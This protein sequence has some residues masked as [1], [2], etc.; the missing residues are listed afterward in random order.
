MGCEGVRCA[1]SD[2]DRRVLRGRRMRAHLRD[3]VV[4]AAFAE[5]VPARRA[6][7]RGLVA[8][9]PPAAAANILSQAMRTGS[10]GGAGKSGG[11]TGLA[12]GT[13]G[14][15]SGATLAVKVGGAAIVAVTAAGA[16]GVVVFNDVQASMG[17]EAR[18]MAPMRSSA[19]TPE[20]MTAAARVQAGDRVRAAL[21]RSSGQTGAGH[22]H[23]AGTASGTA[24]SESARGSVRPPSGA[25]SRSLAQSAP[26]EGAA[27]DGAVAALDAGPRTSSRGHARGGPEKARNTGRVNPRGGGQGIDR[28]PAEGGR[29]MSAPGHGAATRGGSGAQ[30][31]SISGRGAGHAPAGS[32]GKSVSALPA[33]PVSPGP[34]LS[35]KGGHG[36]STPSLGP[37]PSGGPPSV[38]KRGPS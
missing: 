24:P 19:S 12:A 26:A 29:A 18:A 27:E 16:G 9:L 2:G 23:T 14:K 38:R 1:I 33:L 35:A 10:V 20:Q 13:A 4:C 5:A 22:V 15:F 25:G 11:A 8:P 36:P 32:S 30:S 34:P 6:E 31:G 3:C 7:L 28:R 37:Q 21:G 17:A